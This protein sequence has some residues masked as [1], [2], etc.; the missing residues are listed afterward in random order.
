MTTPAQHSALMAGY[1]MLDLSDEKG[2][3]L[4]DLPW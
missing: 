4:P 2:L 1:R 3:A